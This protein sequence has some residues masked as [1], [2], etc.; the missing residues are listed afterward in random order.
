MFEVLA[1]VMNVAIAVFIAGVLFT[2]GLEVTFAQ[3]FRPL[4]NTVVVA[5]GLLAN[6]VLVP[7]LVYGMST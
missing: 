3:A 5:R 2:S 1:I 6:V 7:L 4:R